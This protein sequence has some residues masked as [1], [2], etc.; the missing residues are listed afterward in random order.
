M[1]AQSR[2]SEAQQ[3]RAVVGTW[4]RWGGERWLHFKCSLRTEPVWDTETGAPLCPLGR[5]GQE[6]QA[7]T[8]PEPLE[9]ELPLGEKPA[10]GADLAVPAELGRPVP[11]LV[12]PWGRQQ[13][14]GHADLE[15]R[16]DTRAGHQ[17][18]AYAEM[19]GAGEGCPGAEVQ[20]AP[21]R[22]GSRESGGQSPGPGWHAGVVSRLVGDMGTG[23]GPQT[24]QA[25][26]L[27]T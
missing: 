15:A 14:L 25:R 23:K 11:R 27:V 21:D 18:T 26:P 22:G 13:S 17:H 3:A 4:C 20:A 9:A 2:E 16:P 8:P 10:A 6:R 19:I 7:F 12:G 5:C 1:G 24:Q